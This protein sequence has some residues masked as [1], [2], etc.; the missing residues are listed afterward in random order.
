[1]ASEFYSGQ[2]IFMSNLALGQVVKK[3]NYMNYHGY[4]NSGIRYICSYFQKNYIITHQY[5]CRLLKKFG[6]VRIN[7]KKQK[8]TCEKKLID[9]LDVLIY[10][11]I[12]K[13]V[14]KPPCEQSSGN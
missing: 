9:Q 8:R 12:S 3:V 2:L 1:M 13:G 7:L 11:G 4:K 5:V 14:M 10:Y 6:G